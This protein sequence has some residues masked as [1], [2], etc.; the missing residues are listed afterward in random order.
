MEQQRPTNANKCHNSVDDAGTFCFELLKA[1]K[2]L[3]MMEILDF[4]ILYSKSLAF[5][6]SIL[7]A[8]VLLAT[9]PLEGKGSI[10]RL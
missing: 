10:G 1:S 3:R 9:F 2:F 6:P 8:A 7:A 5:R 4:A